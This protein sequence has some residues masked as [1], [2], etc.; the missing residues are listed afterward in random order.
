MPNFNWP[1]HELLLI[2]SILLVKDLCEVHQLFD[3]RLQ[4][5]RLPISESSDFQGNLAEEVHLIAEE[6]FQYI[7]LE[8]FSSCCNCTNLR[9]I[10][11]FICLCWFTMLRNS[12]LSRIDYFFWKSMLSSPLIDYK[13]QTKLFCVSKLLYHLSCSCIFQRH[14]Y[15]LAI[16][17]VVHLLL[18]LHHFPWFVK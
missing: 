1:R 13:F 10:I 16:A 14:C 6:S 11:S 5:Q 2:S 7:H 3:K 4:I 17:I 18:T 9:V 8:E 15:S 12:L